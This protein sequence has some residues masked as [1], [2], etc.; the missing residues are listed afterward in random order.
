MNAFLQE[1]RSERIDFGLPYILRQ[2]RASPTVA[3]LLTEEKPADQ[4]WGDFAI[5]ALLL[6]VVMARMVRGDFRGVISLLVR[7]VGQP[8]GTPDGRQECP[9]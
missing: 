3:A 9:R 2:L 8:A 5:R 6:Y 4:T 1:S 7:L